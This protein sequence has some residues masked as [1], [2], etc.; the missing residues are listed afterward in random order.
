M[1]VVDNL[2][3]VKA[4]AVSAQNTSPCRIRGIPC[5]YARPLAGSPAVVLVVT[6][7]AA[8]RAVPVAAS[9]ESSSE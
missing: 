9:D 8:P 7:M 1:F 2:K 4:T 5:A 6:P 3:L